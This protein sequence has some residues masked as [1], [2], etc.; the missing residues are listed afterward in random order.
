[1]K[2][3][4][5]NRFDIKVLRDYEERGLLRSQKHP[6]LPLIIW[7]Y[8]NQTQYEYL[9]DDIT[10][11][12]R[13]LVTD[14]MGR[15]HSRPLDKF[16]NRQEEKHNETDDFVAYEKMDGWLGT[17]FWYQNDWV[18]TTRGS[19]DNEVCQWFEKHVRENEPFS[20]LQLDKENTYIF[21][22]IHP[23]TRIVVDYGEMEE[24][25]LL[26]ARNVKDGKEIPLEDIKT[27]F[28]KTEVVTVHDLNAYQKLKDEN[29]EGI[30][31]RFSNGDR[32][33]IK[34]KE[35]FRLSSIMAGC[36]KRNVW[37]ILKNKDDMGALLDNVPDEFRDWVERTIIEIRE[38]YDRV[39][40]VMYDLYATTA[41]MYN[42]D[43][44]K[45]SNIAGLASFDQRMIMC[46]Y[47]RDYVGAEQIIWD[48][49]KP[50]PHLYATY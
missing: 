36:T 20:L 17:I 35:Y 34:L 26:A 44:E 2:A 38:E 4:L 33:K 45:L 30:V 42:Y 49:I 14:I 29:R 1:M 48:K 43:R 46:F 23:L 3:K 9:W 12:C 39:Y 25:F 41:K 37:N 21:E 27:E 8:T 40:S 28:K 16:F 10:L 19:F 24:V 11:A 5:T 32:C 50:G 15:V 22:L 7:N 6:K 47:N 31:I 13:G 18:F